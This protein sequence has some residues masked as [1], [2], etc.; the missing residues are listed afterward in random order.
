MA[1][2][3]ESLRDTALDSLKKYMDSMP[4]SKGKKLAYWVQ[5]YTRFLKHEETFKPQKYVRYKR[6]AVIKAHL[7]YRIGSEQGGLH[8]A[9]VIENDNSIYNPTLTIIPL[10]S[11]KDGFELS[12]LHHSQVYLGDEIYSTINTHLNNEISSAQERLDELKVKLDEEDT[13]KE[14][15]RAE[16]TSIY[17]QIKYCQKLRAEVDKMKIGSIALVGQITTISKIRIY[18]PKYPSDALSKI[19]VSNAT[20]DLLDKKINELF[21]YPQK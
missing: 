13:P 7:G 8:Y 17:E 3:Y 16:L 11:V 21:C 5:D 10:T 15:L 19:R 4:P 6:G 14:D 9:I 1:P 12:K 2:S 18:D 20:L